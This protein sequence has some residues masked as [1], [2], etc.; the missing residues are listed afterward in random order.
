VSGSTAVVAGEMFSWRT[1]SR[2]RALGCRVLGWRER[3]DALAGKVAPDRPE[4]ELEYPCL[5][6]T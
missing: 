3:R 2:G 4:T 1:V 6:S 5:H